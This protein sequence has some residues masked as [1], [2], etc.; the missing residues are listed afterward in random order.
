MPDT[1]SNEDLDV[2]INAQLDEA[3]EKYEKALEKLKRDLD[4]VYF[5]IC[6]DGK[7]QNICFSDLTPEERDKVTEGRSAEWLRSL[8]YHLA[9]RLVEIADFAGVSG[10]GQAD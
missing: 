8:A 5:R 9:D 6:R 1:M 3:Q 2:M 10:N 7:W 4:G